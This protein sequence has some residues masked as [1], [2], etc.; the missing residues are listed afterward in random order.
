[1]GG[2]S[3]WQILILTILFAGV[4]L[5]CI[6]A[7]CSSKAKGHHKFI[8]FLLSLFFLWIGYAAY[9][10]SVIKKLQDESVQ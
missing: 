7:L 1:M 10:F 2:I 5:P 9:Y 6:L 4:I 8:W 3:I